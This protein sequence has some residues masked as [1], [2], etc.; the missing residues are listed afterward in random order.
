MR[1]LESG[2]SHEDIDQ[3]LSS[4]SA[5]LERQQELHTPQE[6]A[7]SL[8]H[9]N[10]FPGTRPYE[11]RSFVYNISQV[12]DWILETVLLVGLMFLFVSVQ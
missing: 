3:Y 10:S 1:F 7:E 6:F 11:T 5:W 4:L 8:R 9:Y 12:R 2:H